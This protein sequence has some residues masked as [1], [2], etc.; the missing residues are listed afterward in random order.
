MQGFLLVVC[1]VLALEMFRVLQIYVR[2]GNDVRKC[3][4]CEEIVNRNEIAY[5]YDY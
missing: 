5:C 4:E 2:S 3:A 1:F